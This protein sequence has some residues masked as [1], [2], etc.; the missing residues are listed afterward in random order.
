M[1]ALWIRI[2]SISTVVMGLNGVCA[3]DPPGASAA[4]VPQ[5]S[6]RCRRVPPTGR[7][8]IGLDEDKF[9]GRE[10]LVAVTAAQ[11]WLTRWVL[12]QGAFSI[13]DQPL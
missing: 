4:L 7:T 8:Y 2:L 6:A 1:R 9:G 12:A 5:Q 10:E 13:T 3:L 11:A